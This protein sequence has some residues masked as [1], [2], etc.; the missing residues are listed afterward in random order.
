MLHQLSGHT[1]DTYCPEGPAPLHA[2]KALP[3]IM[4]DWLQGTV[5]GNEIIRRLEPLVAK[6]DQKP[7][8]ASPL[9][10][11]II[12]KIVTVM[13][14][15]TIRADLY[16]PLKNGIKLLKQ[17]K[18]AGHRVY[19]LSNMDSPL[20]KLLDKKYPEIF[21]LFDGITISGDVQMIKPHANI[22]QHVLKTHAI[23]PSICYVLDDQEENIVG[24]KN[25]GLRAILFTRKTAK[26][27][28]NLLVLNGILPERRTRVGEAS[29]T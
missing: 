14:D 20:I 26:K 10:K 6:L 21:N 28:R 15:P 27:A 22:Y 5:T 1:P 8:F 7:F 29:I 2:G 16:L 23:D 3:K 9:E 13:F 4:C 18:A 25:A 17:C 11:K 24:A 19:L 12:K